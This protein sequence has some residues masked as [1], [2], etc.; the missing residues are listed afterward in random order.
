L[1]ITVNETLLNTAP[2]RTNQVITWNITG[3]NLG[4]SISKSYSILKT[5]PNFTSPTAQT[6]SV[7]TCGA[8]NVC[9]FN[10]SSLASGQS[11]N[12]QF[13][14]T[15]LPSIPL[16]TTQVCNNILMLTLPNQANCFS[17]AT[18]TGCAPVDPNVP[19]LVL[20]KSV[21]TTQYTFKIKYTNIG[22]GPVNNLQ[23]QET[24]QPGWSLNSVSANAGWSCSGS[25]CSQ[26]I[27]NVPFIAGGN[28]GTSLFVVNVNPLFQTLNNGSSQCWVNLVNSTFDDVQFDQTPQNNYAYSPAIGSYCQRCCDPVPCPAANCTQTCPDTQLV[29]NCPPVACKCDIPEQWCPTCKKINPPCDCNQCNNNGVIYA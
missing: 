23:L 6:L 28:S 17:Q 9:S 13:A 10:G 15:V 20:K 25:S 8:N 3:T 5:Y 29:I 11:V 24:L 1:T 22:T 14:V 16:S 7:W 18:T 12:L 2:A 4:T 21:V 19:D 26:T 27:P